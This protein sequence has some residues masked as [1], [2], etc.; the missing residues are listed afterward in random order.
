MEMSWKLG[1]SSRWLNTSSSSARTT[2]TI[3]SIRS[4]QAKVSSA[5]NGVVGTSE[6]L[7][8]QLSVLWST[9]A[10]ASVATLTARSRSATGADV[11]GFDGLD[12]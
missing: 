1:S 3:S 5:R 7:S 2:G 6:C 8:T 9:R 10:P 11:V 12:I 4:T